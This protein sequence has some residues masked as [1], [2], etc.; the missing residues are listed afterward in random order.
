M[1][2][3]RAPVASACGRTARWLRQP[4]LL[5]LLL[6][7][8]GC[9]VV[10]ALAVAFDGYEALHDAVQR[11]EEWQLDEVLTALFI[12]PFGSSFYALRRNAAVRREAAR[13]AEAQAEAQR[14][15][16][17]DPLTGLPNR[18]GLQEA[19]DRTLARRPQGG[20]ALAMIQIDLDRFKPVN[21][22]HGHAAGDLLLQQVA[23]RLRALLRRSDVVARL[24]GDEFVILAPLRGGAEEAARIG[25]R[26]LAGLQ[27]RFD[28]EGV[29]VQID[30]SLGIAIAPAEQEG[31]AASG[32]HHRSDA[33]SCLYRRSDAALYRAK[34]EGRGCLRFFEP[35]MDVQARDQARLRD[36]LRSA[37]QAD[38]LA[39][40]F[41][42]LVDLR[43][44]AT[45]GFEVLARWTHPE[46]GPISPV[47]FIPLAEDAGL[48]SPLMRNIL[49]RA[50]HAARYWPD[51]LSIAVNLSPLQL[52]DRGLVDSVAAILRET[53]FPATRL[54]FELTESALVATLDQ[55][56][57]TILGLK[58]LGVQ[59]SLDDFGTGYS[60]LS[61]LRAL[62]FDKIKIDASFVRSMATEPES[63]KIV[64]AVI[65]LG[66]SLGMVTLAEGIET[67]SQA[68]SLR[69]MGCPL[70]QGWLYGAAS[71]VPDLAGVAGRP[72]RPGQQAGL[73]ALGLS[74]AAA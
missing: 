56:R 71:A 40:H 52:T 34:A 3:P 69:E 18:R 58:A 53:G 12:L 47:Q 26:L 61:H 65:G 64:A 68:R 72:L 31:H 48:I 37:I 17:H 2:T 4:A 10:Y 54:E 1:I 63:R 38:Q 13:R 73:P 27:R 8:A 5:D 42:P 49:R 7:T 36:A 74:S 22:L 11:Y 6:V 33:A 19:L 16:T 32:P 15:A 14:L 24:G 41:Q 29:S 30:A 46:L 20:G 67:E 28:L 9:L 66:R 23:Q 57:A 45:V 43:S 39:P 51:H 55:A 21:D 50:C 44:G 62:P 60:S 59:V 70:G 25:A 35:G